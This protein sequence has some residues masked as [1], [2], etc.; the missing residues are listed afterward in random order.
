MAYKMDKVE[1]KEWLDRKIMDL[2]NLE[3]EVLEIYQHLEKN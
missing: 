2:L 1:L 3:K